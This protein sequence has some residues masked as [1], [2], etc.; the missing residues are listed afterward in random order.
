M[1]EGDGTRQTKG[2]NNQ[3]RRGLF[4]IKVFVRFIGLDPKELIVFKC[5]QVF[6]DLLLRH[7]QLH[8]HSI[9]ISVECPAGLALTH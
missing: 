2:C 5:F 3:R 7:F 9:F 4:E 6:F 8:F 1:S